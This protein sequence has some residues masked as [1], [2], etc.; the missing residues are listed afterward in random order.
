LLTTGSGGV[1]QRV[2]PYYNVLATTGIQRLVN[3]AYVNA[4]YQL[5]FIWHPKAITIYTPQFKSISEKVPSVNSAMFGSWVYKNGDVMIYTQADGTVC[6]IN[7]D[8][9][10]QFYWLSRLEMGFEYQ[11]P[12]LMAPILHLVDESGLSSI[13]NAPVCGSP[14]SS[15]YQYYSDDPVVCQA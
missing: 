6:T 1:L 15:Q 13:V 9:N 5:S 12:K 3:P 4:R 11:Y 14:P 10:D 8:N 2:Y 7:N